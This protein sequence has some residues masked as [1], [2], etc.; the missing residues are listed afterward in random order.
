MGVLKRGGALTFLAFFFLNSCSGISYIAEN[1]LNQWKLF[2][3]ARPVEELKTSPHSNEEFLNAI[4]IVEKAK[5]YSLKIG[6]KATHSYNSFVKLNGPCLVWAVAAAHP[7]FLEEKKWKF[8]IVGEVPYLGFFVEESAV[9]EAKRIKEKEEADVWVRCVPAF[10]SLGWFADPLY[11]SMLSG[12]ER[13]I[14]ELVIHESVHATVWV[15]SSVDFNEKFAN[16]VGLEG[17]L[18]YIKENKGAEA[19]AKAKLEVVGEKILGEFFVS[20]LSLHKSS[21]KDAVSKAK[22]FEEQ[23]NRY[24]QFVSTKLSSGLKFIPRDFRFDR[25]NNAALLAY[26]NYYS[27]FSVFE[28]MLSLCGGDLS[29]FMGWIEH[30]KKSGRFVGAPEEHLVDLVKGSS[31]PT[32][33]G[34]DR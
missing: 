3:R 33:P 34:L 6:L 32:R 8:P 26:A 11:S 4:A 24:K 19:F 9:K 5:A 18:S 14:V 12:S 16:F 2:N 27:D 29:R 23:T 31:C 30:E 21:V 17:S 7:V 1:G 22:F 20:E 15:G 10:S 13:D 25:W 28:K